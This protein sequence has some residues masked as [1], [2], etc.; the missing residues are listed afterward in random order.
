MVINHMGTTA[1]SKNE[2]TGER[3]DPRQICFGMVWKPGID[4]M[5]AEQI[6][7]YCR[8]VELTNWFAR[9]WKADVAVFEITGQASIAALA[10]H[11]ALK[12]GLRGG[13]GSSGMRVVVGLL[14]LDMRT[15]VIGAVPEVIS[16]QIQLCQ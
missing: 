5:S 12:D 13:K 8:A 11:V 6:V 7:S 4:L 3:R 15:V 1:V 10:R 16:C 14:R 2:A 9:V